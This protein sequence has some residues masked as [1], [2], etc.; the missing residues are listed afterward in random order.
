M[1]VEQDDPGWCE[2]DDRGVPVRLDAGLRGRRAR[3]G[4]RA[5]G[6]QRRPGAVVKAVG[7]PVGQGFK[8]IGDRCRVMFRVAREAPF[9]VVRFPLPAVEEQG[10]YTRVARRDHVRGAV[11]HVPDVRVRRQACGFRRFQDDVR[12]RLVGGYVPRADGDVDQ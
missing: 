2:V 12:I 4:R 5:L 9:N 8:G 1:P 3:V 7:D 10:R 6:L 11:A